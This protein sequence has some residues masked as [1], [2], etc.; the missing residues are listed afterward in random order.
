[1]NDRSWPAAACR[2][3]LDP[4]QRLIMLSNEERPGRKFDRVVKAL[5]YRYIVRFL[6][7]DPN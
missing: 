7:K 3:D 1:M 4:S 2:A 5:P 6:K